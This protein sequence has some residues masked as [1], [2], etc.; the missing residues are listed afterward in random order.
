MVFDERRGKLVVYGGMGVMTPGAPPP[1]LSDHWEFDGSAWTQVQLTGPTP[2]PPP[3][4][5]SSIS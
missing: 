4:W 1:R 3:C 2:G 5:T